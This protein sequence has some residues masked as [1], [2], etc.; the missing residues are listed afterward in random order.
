MVRL[1]FTM[2]FM[3]I[4]VLCVGQKTTAENKILFS[5]S[6][7]KDSVSMGDSLKITISYKNDSEDTLKLYSE[8]RVVIT[9]YST[10]F[11]TYESDERLG[12]I[13]REYSNRNSIIWL[14]PKE[15]IKYTF[16]IEAKEGFFYEGENTIRIH[17]RNIWDE[18]TEWKRRK[19]QKRKEQDTVIV[20]RSSPIKITVNNKGSTYFFS[21]ETSQLNGQMYLGGG[22]WRVT[23]ENDTW[24]PVPGLVSP[25]GPESDRF[26]TAAVRFDITGGRLKGASAG[27]NIFTGQASWDVNNGTFTD[28]KA[29][30]YRLGAI[31]AGYYNAR[32]GYNSERGI[33]GP[34]QNGFHDTQ[35]YP[36]FKVLSGP[37]RLYFGI[38]SSNPYTLW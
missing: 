27:L 31:Y 11:I 1:I 33:R 17:Y 32:I 6:F 38:Y 28:P 4:I 16:D 19:K 15:E 9:H 35:N 34:I 20:L 26:R 10:M 37:E 21:G 22:N 8:G 7:N 18:P 30:K 25:G 5:A 23:Y 2:I 29:N 14:K 12:Y 3:H 13:L 24:A 36:H